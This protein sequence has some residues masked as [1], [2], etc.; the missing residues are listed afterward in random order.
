MAHPTFRDPQALVPGSKMPKLNLLD[1]EIQDLV[2]Y[3][4]T[5]GVQETYSA[6]A[7]KLFKSNCMLC[8]KLGSEGESIGPDLSMIG[9]ARDRRISSATF[10]NL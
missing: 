6:E 9:L 2:A 10:K 5:L 8:H 4:K 3:I 1:D 7:P